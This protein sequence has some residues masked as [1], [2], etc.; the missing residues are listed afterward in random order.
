MPKPRTAPGRFPL[1]ALAVLAADETN[2]FSRE[3]FSESFFKS[4]LMATGLFFVQSPAASSVQCVIVRFS[5][6]I[7]N[8][9]IFASQQHRAQGNR[10]KADKQESTSFSEEKEAKRLCSWGRGDRDCL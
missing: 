5:A 1:A 9:L 2:S 6:G 4:G 10:M 8:F 3:N 7:K